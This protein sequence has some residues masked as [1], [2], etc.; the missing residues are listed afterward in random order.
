MK[1]NELKQLE[2]LLNNIDNIIFKGI[3]NAKCKRNNKKFN[4]RYF[5][6]VK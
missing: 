3:K 4:E 5:K 6:K 1:K 2:Y